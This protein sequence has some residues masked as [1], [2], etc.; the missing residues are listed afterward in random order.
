MASTLVRH[1][2]YIV[3]VDSLARKRN[4]VNLMELAMRFQDVGP[5]VFFLVAC[6]GCNARQPSGVKPA[7][8]GE[9]VGQW[10]LIESDDC[11]SVAAVGVVYTFR[12]NGTLDVSLPDG[13]RSKRPLPSTYV[14][15]DDGT[16]TIAGSAKGQSSTVPYSIHGSTLT[17]GSAEDD[18]FLRLERVDASATGTARENADAPPASMSGIPPAPSAQQ[19]TEWARFSK[20]VDLRRQEFPFRDAWGKPLWMYV[21]SAASKTRSSYVIGLYKARVLF[22]ESREAMEKEAQVEVDR[23]MGERHL[24]MPAICAI[25]TRSDGRKVFF[26]QTGFG[27]GGDGRHAFTTIGQ[28]DLMVYHVMSEE[29]SR[30][31]RMA[32]FAEVTR[33]LGQFF[34][35]LEAHI[36]GN[37]AYE[38]SESTPSTAH[39]ERIDH[40]AD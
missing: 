19:V 17:I 10:R 20:P 7:P 22:G 8:A 37:E 25:E 31:E 5:I 9:V 1:L 11:P 4:R 39:I 35:D 12:A 24:D 38:D 21:Y 28:Y 30:G 6:F 3:V 40:D 26:I 13:D 29:T 36:A 32:D 15:S 23:A 16:L 27:P 18:F 34:K 14:V 2:D 33:T